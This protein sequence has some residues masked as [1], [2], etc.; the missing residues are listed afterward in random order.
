MLED[1]NRKVMGLN[2]GAGKKN[3]DHELSVN[4]YF[5]DHLAEEFVQLTSERCIMYKLSLVYLRQMYSEFELKK[6]F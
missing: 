6:V 1:M 4:V 2:P 3:F 5:Y